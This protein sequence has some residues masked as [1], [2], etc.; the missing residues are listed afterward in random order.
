M[1]PVETPCS[2]CHI[3]YKKDSAPFD[4]QLARCNVCKKRYV[5]EILLTTIE[6]PPGVKFES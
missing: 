3:P 2:Y 6:P 1:Y 4:M 5:P